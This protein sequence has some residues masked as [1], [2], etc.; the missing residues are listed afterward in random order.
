VQGCAETAVRLVSWNIRAGGGVRVAALAARLASWRPDV[1]ALCEFRATPPSAALAQA[2]AAQGLVHQLTTADPRRPPENALL[3]AS[4]WPLRPPAAASHSPREPA[5]W[6][7]AEVAAPRPFALG[8]MHVPNR[9]TGRKWPFLDAVL[10]LATAWPE[11]PAVFLGDTNSGRPGL[12]EARG[13]RSGFNAREGGFLD[14]LEAAGWR[15]AFRHLHGAARA[16]TWYSPNLGN[17]F[18][19]DQA[20]LSPALVPALR[21]V[22]HVWGRRRAGGRPPGGPSDHAALLVDLS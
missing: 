9:E 16:Y 2:L 12:D 7:L 5:R 19:I 8:A 6:L 15:D 3:V 22:R 1:A 13:T 18:R 4:R 21:A 20:F 11:A 14:G 17:G 10:A